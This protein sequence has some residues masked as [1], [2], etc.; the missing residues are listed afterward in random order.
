MPS[1][2][3]GEDHGDGRPIRICS[4][5][6]AHDSPPVLLQHSYR[7]RAG[8][9]RRNQSFGARNWIA[10]AP[11]VGRHGSRNT[12]LHGGF[13]VC[14]GS[15]EEQQYC[16]RPACFDNHDG[17]ALLRLAHRYHNLLHFG[18]WLRLNIPASDVWGCD[19]LPVG[20]MCGRVSTTGLG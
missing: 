8:L 15:A 19:F 14:V 13:A 7:T 17:A 4:P 12:L 1:T 3:K 16:L 5:R 18:I 2:V 9:L 20:G 10:A 6:H 11:L